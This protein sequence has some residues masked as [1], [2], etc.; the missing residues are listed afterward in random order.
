MLCALCLFRQSSS[1]HGLVNPGFSYVGL[2]AKH[3]SRSKIKVFASTR[4]LR[5]LT[6]YAAPLDN[7]HYLP[8]DILLHQFGCPLSHQ[9]VCPHC[10]NLVALI[11]P[12]WPGL[13]HQFGCFRDHCTNLVAHLFALGPFI[14]PIW[15]PRCANL[16]GIIAPIWL[17][18]HSPS[19]H[20]LR[21]LATRIVPIWPP[22]CTNLVAHL[23][24]FGEYFVRHIFN[25]GFSDTFCP[26]KERGWE[27]GRC[28]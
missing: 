8:S 27:N 9:I 6:S 18:I 10:A 7:A 23:S 1:S 25:H 5:R 3:S 12:I 16:A 22:F 4:P 19:S 17:P 15:S 28:Y 21:Q 24:R 14:A 2:V 13:L 11:V 20:L 26:C